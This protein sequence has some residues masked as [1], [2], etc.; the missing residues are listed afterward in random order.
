[1]GGVGKTTISS[2]LVRQDSCR[3]TYDKIVWVPLGQHPNLARCQEMMLIQL[4][5]D[6]FAD[7]MSA[8]QK[9]EE[10]NVA[11]TGRSI[12]LVLDDAWEPEHI[13]VRVTGKPTLL[14]FTPVCTAV[15]RRDRRYYIL[16]RAPV[17]ACP[18]PPRARR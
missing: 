5:G 6:R 12:L 11:M 14:L 3:S 15:A 4:N 16:T 17:L 7:G 9:K 2:W 10:L 18:R 8:D 13:A 1:M